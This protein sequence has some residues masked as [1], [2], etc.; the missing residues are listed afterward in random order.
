MKQEQIG[1]EL[2]RRVVEGSLPPGSRLPTRREL[3]EEFDASL[4]TVQKALDQLMRD[5]FVVARGSQGTFVSANPPHLSHYGVVFPRYPGEAAFPRAWTAL[6][7][8]A[9]A[10]ERERPGR[11]PIYYGM[12]G[13]SDTE[14]YQRLV[15]DVQAH[16]LAGL[17]FATKPFL[18]AGTPV[19]DEPNVPRVA[20]MGPTDNAFPCV[21]QDVQS[22]IDRAL[23]HLASRGRRRL[24]VL[25]N[26]PNVVERFAAAAAARQMEH[27]PYWMQ[28]ASLHEPAFSRNCIH[29][30]MR[31]GQRER[32]DA[33]V[34]ADD[35]MLEHATAGLVA[36]GVRVPEDVEV[37]AH[38]NFPWPTSSV[39]PV[40]RLGFD[41]RQVLRRCIESIDRQRGGEAMPG[42]MY[43]PAVF[44]DELD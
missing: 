17:I 27:P 31:D 35:N 23:G 11:F 15:R 3:E 41:S 39:L 38:C 36:A 33:L 32:P 9:M 4:H 30:L 40:K 44:E 5:G 37:V 8:E 7:N 10:M 43:V 19:V 42:P 12:D 18:L 1:V 20:I 25:A 16:R 2:R 22:F 21:C 34:I 24:A 13:H 26:T 29:L 14:D 6:A 28:L